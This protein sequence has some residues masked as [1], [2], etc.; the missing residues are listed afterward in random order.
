MLIYLCGRSNS[1][2]DKLLVRNNIS[3]SRVGSD[4]VCV[5]LG[6]RPQPLALDVDFDS[7]TYNLIA[8][9]FLA[10]LRVSWKNVLGIAN[11]SHL[12]KL[13]SC[14]LITS[15]VRAKFCTFI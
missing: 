6:Q 3:V 15:P 9:P 11:L 1:E 10:E 13:R 14:R 12:L 2:D 8:R 5:D 7:T 4:K